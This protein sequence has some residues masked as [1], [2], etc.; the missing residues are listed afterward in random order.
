MKTL[1]SIKEQ[2]RNLIYKPEKMLSTVVTDSSKCKIADLQLIRFEWKREWYEWVK[3]DDICFVISADHYVKALINC[4]N[5]PKWMSRH[6]TIKELIA[7]LS[8]SNFIR[9][10]R[11]YLLNC[12]YF[13]HL[14]ERKK[15]LFLKNGFFIPVPHRIPPYILLT[16]KK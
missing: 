3:P 12:N 5:K 13:T 15:I 14:D 9:L 7:I 6:C 2:T 10:N 1:S 4:E 16:F 11:F 8:M